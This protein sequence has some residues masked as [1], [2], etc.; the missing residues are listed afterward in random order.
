MR[1]LWSMKSFV[2]GSMR[3]P[4]VLRAENEAVSLLT[5]Q[6]LK[7]RVR[8]V[9]DLG[10]G[11]GNALSLLPDKFDLMVGI[12]VSTVML[13]HTR[14]IHGGTVVIAGDAN[15]VPIRDGA[16]DLVLCV[17]LAEYVSDLRVVLSEVCRLLADHGHAIV[18]TAPR[19]ALS[20]ARC[21][22]GHR[23]YP[24]GDAEVYAAARGARLEVVSS[25]RTSLQCQWL[26]RAMDASPRRTVS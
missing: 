19:R 22:L 17:G 20:Y 12:D 8:S 1:A 16:I 14:L 7:R 13:R 6:A 11:R 10:A 23:V 4:P 26:L 3:V 24:R 25:S 15:A 21:A 18:T 5:R 9:L 2:Y